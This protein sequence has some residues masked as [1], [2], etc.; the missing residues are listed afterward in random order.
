MIERDSTQRSE[1]QAQVSHTM[2]ILVVWYQD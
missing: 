2:L 1:C